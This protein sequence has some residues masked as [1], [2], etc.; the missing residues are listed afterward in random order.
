MLDDGTVMPVP[1]ELVTAQFGSAFRRN[2]KDWGRESLFQFLWARA[3][4]R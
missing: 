3:D 4:H 2:A 1:D